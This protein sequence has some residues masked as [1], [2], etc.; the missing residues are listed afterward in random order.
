MKMLMMMLYNAEGRIYKFD[1]ETGYSQ[2]V[3]TG[4]LTTAN[5]DHVLARDGSEQTQLTFDNDLNTWFPHISPDNKKVVMVSY[6][7]G[8]LMPGEHVPNKNVEL[9]LMN[10]DGS[11]IKTIVKLY[12][13]QGTI[14][15]N[16]WAPDSKKFAFVSYKKN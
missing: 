6:Y 1:L 4:D 9:R 7:K 14:N 10:A 3:D 15:V 2:I 5:N 12:G 16:S 8:D 13:G 11:D